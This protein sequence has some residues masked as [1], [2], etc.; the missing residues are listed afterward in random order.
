MDR[1]EIIARKMGVMASWGYGMEYFN[2]HFDDPDFLS[3][4]W[5]LNWYGPG[6]YDNGLLDEL[7]AIDLLASAARG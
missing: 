1:W 6:F 2:E 3:E 7:N 5:L 4:K